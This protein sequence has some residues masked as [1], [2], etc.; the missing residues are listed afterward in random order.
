MET[1]PHA[2]AWAVLFHCFCLGNEGNGVSRALALPTEALVLSSWELG[3][4]Q[5][6]AEL[7]AADF[8]P[9]PWFTGLY[10]GHVA[11]ASCISKLDCTASSE[12]F[13]P[14]FLWR[15]QE[16]RSCPQPFFV[17]S[18]RNGMGARPA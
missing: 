1:N 6:T 13:L 2:Q 5:A 3:L 14:S 17:S 11:A 4:A 8:C 16:E 12:H 18:H 7:A 9:L 15:S 10:K